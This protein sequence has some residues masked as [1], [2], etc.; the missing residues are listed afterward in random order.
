MIILTIFLN[1]DIDAVFWCFVMPVIKI[2]PELNM[3]FE[4]PHPKL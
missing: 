1:A 2:Y 3:N 4:C